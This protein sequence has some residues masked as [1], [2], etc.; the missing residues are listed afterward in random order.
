MHLKRPCI[1]FLFIDINSNI[2]HRNRS[3]IS[4]DLLSKSHFDKGNLHLTHIKKDCMRQLLRKVITVY[5]KYCLLY[6]RLHIY[7]TTKIVSFAFNQLYSGSIIGRMAERS[8]AL[9]LGTSHFGGAS[10]NLAPVNIVHRRLQCVTVSNS[11]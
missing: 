3:Q 10:S 11:I 5:W 8:K 4:T 6:K 1:N 2:L 9:V 7:L